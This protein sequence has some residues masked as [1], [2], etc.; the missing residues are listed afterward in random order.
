MTQQAPALLPAEPTLDLTAFANAVNTSHQDGATMVVASSHNDVP[1]LAFKG[2]MMVWDQD[3][4]A[5]WERGLKE[6]LAALQSNPRIAAVLKRNGAVRFDGEAILVEDPAL[7]EAIWE[8]VIPEEKS[9]DPDKKGRA[10]LIKVNRVRIG[11]KT[12]SR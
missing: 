12:A 8:R 6:T 9:K 10:V 2:S 4:L 1:D 7:R 11:A 5:Y 3:H